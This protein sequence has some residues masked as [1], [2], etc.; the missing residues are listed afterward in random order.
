MSSRR[1]LQALQ[2]LHDPVLARNRFLALFLLALDDQPQLR[3]PLVRD[4]RS[5][6]HRA[7]RMHS[8]PLPHAAAAQ[9]DA[10]PNL[11]AVYV[12]LGESACYRL[13]RVLP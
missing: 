1:A 13:N 10:H 12:S 2:R 6:D 7:G 8:V 5:H 9:P 4:H 3:I 11:E